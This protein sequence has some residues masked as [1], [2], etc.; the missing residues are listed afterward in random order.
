MDSFDFKCYICL[1]DSE[2]VKKDFEVS[3]TTFK[4]LLVDLRNNYNVIFTVFED[5]KFFYILEFDEVF[6]FGSCSAWLDI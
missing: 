1:R 5:F 2:N 3:S 6:Y 4:S